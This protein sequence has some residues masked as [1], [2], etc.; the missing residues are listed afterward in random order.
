MVLSFSDFFKKEADS[1]K[2][3]CEKYS[4]SDY[5]AKLQELVLFISN[6]LEVYDSYSMK[7]INY[8]EFKNRVLN[9]EAKTEK[10]LTQVDIPEKQKGLVKEIA[11]IPKSTT[12][13]EITEEMK[14]LI[15]DAFLS[16]KGYKKN[17]MKYLDLISSQ[18]E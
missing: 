17:K 7:D 10:K 11:E 1:L 12:V 6:L 18:K 4:L 5:K 16:M 9:P 13:V 3:Q 15:N 14:N 2:L 8:T